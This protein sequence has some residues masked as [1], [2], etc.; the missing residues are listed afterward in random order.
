MSSENNNLFADAAW[1][2]SEENHGYGQAPIPTK[3]DEDITALL[4]TWRHMKP[5][6]RDEVAEVIRS[7][8]LLTL[9]AYGERMAS[10]G[11]RRKDRET[12]LLGLLAVGLSGWRED[13]R[14][15]MMVLS[16][17]FDASQKVGEPPSSLFNDA[18][19]LLPAKI[20]SEL[21]TFLRRSP[22][23]RSLE[24]M[25]YRVGTDA[26]GFRYQYSGWS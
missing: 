10:L 1:L 18:A 3:R 12:L 11:V 9:L 16:L 26:D 24:S 13:P 5:E 6:A 8:Q 19:S 2:K 20:G 4:R 15:G 25:G 23:D 7:D 21:R 17:F 14:E 22:E